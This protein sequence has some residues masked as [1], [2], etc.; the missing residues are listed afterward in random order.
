LTAV[1]YAEDRRTGPNP[2]AT[3]LSEIDE[4]RLLSHAE[5]RE[6]AR[7]VAEGDTEARDRMVRANLRLVVNVARRY[8]GKGLPLEDLIAEG[9]L[10]LLRAVEGFDP[11]MSTRFSTYA[12]YWI[13]QSIRR[14]LNTAGRVVRL[15]HYAGG[16]V[17]KWRQA[18]AE[19]QAELGRAPTH[20]EV[21]A[22]LELPKRKV[23]VVMSALRV[24]G[25]TQEAESA[26]EG[27]AVAD[28]VADERGPAPGESVAGAEE[29][30]LAL[31][32]LDDMG[33]REVTVLR[34]RFGLDG[35][36]PRTLQ[37]IGERIGCTRER[38]RQIERDALAKLREVFTAC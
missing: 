34:L 2:F 36:A 30:R 29:L 5:E 14:A 20:E 17:A 18:A 16:L 26:D 12:C 25:A 24:Y 4:T 22:R 10:G 23:R 28:L 19:M 27:A 9:N 6:L 35:E 3:Y 37:Q 7:R 33:E 15:P 38:V 13:K 32:S 8:T 21:A 31:A 11:D 1:R